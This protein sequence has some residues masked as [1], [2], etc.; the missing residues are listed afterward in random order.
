MLLPLPLHDARIS[1]IQASQVQHRAVIRGQV[2]IA[3]RVSPPRP[4]ATRAAARLASVNATPEQQQPHHRPG[5]RKLQPKLNR[6]HATRHG[7]IE[8]QPVHSRQK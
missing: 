7:H 3:S 1:W 2:C 6:H 8:R 4:V 5:A